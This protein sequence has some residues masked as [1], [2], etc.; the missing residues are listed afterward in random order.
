MVDAALAGLDRGEIVTIPSLPDIAQ[1]E[2]YEAARQNMLPEPV[3]HFAP[4]RAMAS[5]SNR[6]E[7]HEHRSA[8]A[9]RSVLAASAAAGAFGFILPTRRDP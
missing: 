8:R 7:H 3:T 6:K 5:L 9:R 1:W 4:Q 2:A